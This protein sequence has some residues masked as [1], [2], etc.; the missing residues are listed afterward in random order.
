M[1]RRLALVSLLLAVLTPDVA[2]AGPEFGPREYQVTVR[3]PETV[4]EDFS[5][6]G[7]DRPFRIRIENGAGGRAR[8]SSGSVR[9]NGIEVV[10]ERDFNQQV[11]L[12]ERPVTLQAKNTVGIRLAGQPGGTIRVSVIGESTCL[13]V[14]LTSP[15]PGARVPPGLTPVRGVVRGPAGAGVTVNGLPA[16]VE[17]ESFV[18][19]FLADASV[20]DLV[21]VATAPDGSTAET[22][23]SVEV[24]APPGSQESLVRL[25]PS[26]P[27]GLAPLTIGFSLSSLVGVGWISVDLRGTG[28]ADF[29][30]TSLEGQAFRY[31]Q[32]GIYTPTVT[33][34]DVQGRAHTATTL[35]H[36]YDGAALDAR[37]QAVWQGLKDA[38]RSG[39]MTRAASFVHTSRRT[40]YESQFR[41]L[42]PSVLSNIDRYLP[43]IQLVEVGFAGAQYEMLRQRDG[44]TFSFAVWFQLDADGI[45]RLQ[46][47]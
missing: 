42:T 3:G 17:G 9:V 22:R 25:T 28:S 4:T 43:A 10:R 41:R 14:T 30:G 26:P 12:I 19:L 34:T 40:A 45:W 1:D 32:P 47:F 46:R 33:V 16:F 44:Q 21:A 29:E 39:D 7:L 35:V 2:A 27:G 31:D 36:A 38:L 18:G 37:L 15:S 23:Q 13:E 8:V 6:C 20:S 11:A 24:L 5:A